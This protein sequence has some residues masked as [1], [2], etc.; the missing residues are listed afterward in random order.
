MNKYILKTVMCSALAV[1]TLTSCELDQ[2][3]DSAL[4]TEQSWQKLSDA[5]NYNNGILA[6]IRSLSSGATSVSEVQADLFNLRASSV[7]NYQSYMWTFTNT[8]FD[9]DGL[10]SGSY[11][12]IANANNVINN[13]D[14][15]KTTNDSDKKML[16]H[17]KGNA[18]FLRAYALSNMAPRYCSRYT[19]DEEAKT[20]KGLPLLTE[21][22]VNKKPSRAS[23]YDTYQFIM[24]DLQQARKLM[25]DVDNTDYTTMSS[26]VAEALQARVLLY[27]NKHQEALDTVADLLTRYQLTDDADAYKEMWKTDAIDFGSELIYEP[28]MTADDRANFGSLYNYRYKQNNHVFYQPDY[29]PTQGLID[30]YSDDDIRK[31][32]TFFKAEEEDTSE[33]VII[34][35]G[36]VMSEG[37]VFNKYPGNSSLTKAGESFD[38]Y[39]MSKP[40]RTAELYLIGAEASYHLDGTDGGYLKRL[41]QAR[42]FTTNIATGVALFNNI[43]DEWIR[44]FVGENFRLY[45]LKR[46][47][48]GFKRMQPQDGLEEGILNVEGVK[49]FSISADN[50]R[51][52]WEIPSQELQANPNIERNW[53]RDN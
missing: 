31:I 38:F 46:W 34:T 24:N 35:A 22:D 51:W 11:T 49:D 32:G 28:Q 12:A 39:N 37:V 15:V 7:T 45:N 8:Q 23:L 36:D 29:L 13:I 42:G 10:W 40:F 26:N 18:L 4:V 43:K 3:P 19:T 5:E 2:Y 50:Q 53:G 44:E 20:I 30:L 33:P 48:D 25:D 52:N 16:E 17:Y 9:G 27:M 41:Q 6:Y 14:K 47:G 1:A 21:E